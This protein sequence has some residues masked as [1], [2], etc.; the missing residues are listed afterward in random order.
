[1]SIF[2]RKKKESIVQ[3][4]EHVK[5]A[6][7]MIQPITA[8]PQFY[9]SGYSGGTSPTPKYNSDVLLILYETVSKLNSVVNYIAS[10]GAEIPVKHYRYLSNGKKKDLGQTELIKFVD[11]ISVETAIVQLI[12][13]GNLFIHKFYTPGFTYPTKGLIQPSNRFY[14]IPQNSID[15]YG[16]PSTMYDVFDNPIIK[17]SK[18]IQNGILKTYTLE[19]TIHIKDIQ[20]N[21]TG[22]DFYYG[23]ARLYAAVDTSRTLKYL[24]ETINSLLNNGGA[25]GFISRNA[26]QNELDPGSYIDLV[27]AAEKR[28][29]EDF[30]TT[31]G[32]H[33]IMATLADLKYN[34]MSSPI[35]EFLPVELS[36]MEFDD[37]CNQ[38]GGFPSLLLNAKTNASYNNMK[39]AK[40]SFYSNCLS[41]LLFK[42][43]SGISIDLKINQIGEWLE[44]DFSGV[45]EMQTDRKT[46]ADALVSE[47][48]YLTTML[49][50]KL[51]TKNTFLEKM[52]FETNS[53]PSFSEIAQSVEPAQ[54]VENGNDD[55]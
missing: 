49:D 37:I 2:S 50:K 45:P 22:K 27:A 25:I 28:I 31:N 41:P 7:Q 15:Q 23:T 32:R 4:E 19:E 24:A 40:S 10:R 55:I 1:M 9:Y 18:L 26:K 16:T 44:P 46:E 43:Y 52:G 36:A 11:T 53:D 47:S 51:I 35:N 14:A 17:Y 5:S 21:L 6:N 33:T 12:V 54:I 29:N 48:N 42:I 3:P 39:E 38:M 13:Q 30:G 20:A 34:K 8:E